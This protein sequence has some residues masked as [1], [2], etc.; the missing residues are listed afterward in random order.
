MVENIE[1]NNLNLAFIGYKTALTSKLEEKVLEARKEVL[2]LMAHRYI[3]EVKKFDNKNHGVIGIVELTE[4]LAELTEKDSN[5]LDRMAEIIR[6]IGQFRGD[7]GKKLPEKKLSFFA[8]L[9]GF[10]KKPRQVFEGAH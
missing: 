5:D 3:T 6:E 2:L 4:Q 9:F 8:K 7:Y 1:F 10:G